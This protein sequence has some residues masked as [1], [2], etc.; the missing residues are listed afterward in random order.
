MA[1]ATPAR[2]RPA[3]PA[4]PRPAR[5]QQ[6]LADN[7]K[8]AGHVIAAMGVAGRGAPYGAWRRGGAASRQPGKGRVGTP[9]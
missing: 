2:S 6:L 7:Y 1:L 8:V 4:P 5:S 3:S 9:T